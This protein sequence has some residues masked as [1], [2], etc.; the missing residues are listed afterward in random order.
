MKLQLAKHL[1]KQNLRF[2]LLPGRNALSLAVCA[3]ILLWAPLF[4]LADTQPAAAADTSVTLVLPLKINTPDNKE[5]LTETADAALAKVLG[6]GSAR[7]KGFKFMPRTEAEKIFDYGAAWP[8]TTEKLQAFGSQSAQSVHYVAAGSL[9]KLGD[10]VSI[11]IKVFDLLDPS[12]PKFYYLEGQEVSNLEQSLTDITG[13]ILSYTGRSFLIASIAP[14]GN[15][16]IDSGAILRN[17]STRAGDF[18]EPEKLRDDLKNVFK[19]GYFDDVQLKVDDTEKGKKVIFEVKEKPVIGQ[20]IISG[21][22]E[23]KEEAIRDVISVVPNTILNPNKTREA[24]ENIKNLYK[25]KG[26]YNTEVTTELTYPKPERVDIHFNIAEGEKVYIKEIRFEGNESFKDKELEKVM[27]TKEKGLL[28]W[29]NDSGVLKREILEQDAA[30]ITAF[31]NNH[32]FI[33]AMVGQP[34]ITQE[35]KWLYITIAISEG[36][37][38]KVGN[39]D[40]SGDLIADKKE[41]LDLLKLKDE[42]YLNRGVLRQD[43]LRLNDYYAEHGFAFAESTPTIKTDKEK[44][45][46]DVNIHITKGALVYINRITIKGNTRTRD[47]VIRRQLE[48]KEKGIFD[49]KALRTSHQQLQRLDYFEEVSITPEP[50]AD[51]TK[52]D[53]N[54]EVKEKPTGAFSIGAGYSS[55]DKLMFV[56]EISQNNFLG[57]GQ[58]L[59]LQANLSATSTRYNLSFTEPYFY[60]TQLLVGLDL[61]NWV[62]E[63]DTYTRDSHGFAARFGYPIWEEWHATFSYGFDDTELDDVTADADP[64]IKASQNINTT[65]FVS[66]GFNRDTRNNLYVTTNGSLN[67]LRLEYAGGPLQ[68]DSQYTKLEGSTSWFFPGLIGD[69]TAFHIKFAAGQVWENE[70]NK[71]PDFEKFYLGGIDSL[72]GFPARTVAVPVSGTN[73]YVG[74]EIMWYTNLEYQFPL[75]KQGGLRGLVFYDAGNV[76]DNEW[77]FDDIRQD[78]GVGLRWM[79]PMGPMRLEWAYVIDPRPGDDPTNFEFSIGG[80]F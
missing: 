49:S 77:N 44:K 37:R 28:S 36:N 62:R 45:L 38:Y 13:D 4:L 63:Y 61:Y 69:D 9:T 26:F 29:F 3:F 78:V 48:V 47:K 43:L 72:R 55:V 74:G 7:Q 24:V 67:S 46:V 30:R 35:G 50:T 51:K 33:E 41:L 71:L 8:P 59:A 15:K 56:G 12:T 76:Y 66:L 68:G 58:R 23:L 20:V 19:M 1:R 39:I 57:Y 16:R 34:K 32:G 42:K 17:I 65:S 40:L 10:T 31:Y 80:G 27:G 6:T 79:S 73:D 21:Q 25:S 14:E 52:M 53:L 54:V 75:V 18:Y 5:N 22:D 2:T 11:D 60:D 70:K 64:A